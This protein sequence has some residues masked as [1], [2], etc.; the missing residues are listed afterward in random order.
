[1]TATAAKPPTSPLKGKIQRLPISKIAVDWQRQ[2]LKNEWR[3]RK[4]DRTGKGWDL[5]LLK[6]IRLGKIGVTLTQLSMCYHCRELYLTTPGGPWCCS[7]ACQTARRDGERKERLANREGRCQVC[8]ETFRV[9]RNTARTC[10]ERCRKALQ[11][12]PERYQA[13]LPPQ[14]EKL[15]EPYSSWLVDRLEAKLMATER[16]RRDYQK[17]NGMVLAV[18]LMG[19]QMRATEDTKLAHTSPAVWLSSN[20]MALPHL[21][22]PQPAPACPVNTPAC[23]ELGDVWA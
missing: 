15:S 12:H 8:G 19:H 9:Q 22:Q 14:G 10:S 16:G 20:P 4:D 13:A 11:R 5:Q 2:L 21:H 23:P 7:D 3:D 6:P 18:M 1:M 17:S